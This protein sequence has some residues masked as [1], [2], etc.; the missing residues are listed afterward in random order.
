[1]FGVAAVVH[2]FAFA[3][4]AGVIARQCFRRNTQGLVAVAFVGALL[5]LSAADRT[6]NIMGMN[7]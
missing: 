6:S 3:R 4:L 2:I 1:M 5:R 7:I